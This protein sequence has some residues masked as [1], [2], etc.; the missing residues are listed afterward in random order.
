[1]EG[2]RFFSLEELQDICQLCKSVLSHTGPY[3]Y[4]N[5]PQNV[6]DLAP[7]SPKKKLSQQ[8]MRSQHST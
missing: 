5:G 6:Q 2:G 4:T 8:T 7:M 1:M 3:M